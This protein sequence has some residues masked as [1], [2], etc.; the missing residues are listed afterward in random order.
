[1]TQGHPERGM[2]CIPR[3]CI[4]ESLLQRANVLELIWNKYKVVMR[5]SRTH[6]V[7]GI[8]TKGNLC[9]PHDSLVQARQLEA[10]L[11]GEVYD[12]T[13]LL[14]YPYQICPIDL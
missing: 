14:L 12:A 8:S 6:R 5:S 11:L 4:P 13:A 1:M 9:S 3:I 10:G 2:V 7:L